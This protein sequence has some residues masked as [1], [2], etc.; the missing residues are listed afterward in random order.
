MTVMLNN[1]KAN[2][3]RGDSSITTSERA[4]RIYIQ[5]GAFLCVAPPLVLYM[6]TQKY[7]TESIERT[8]LVG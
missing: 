3:A 5:A 2:L 7:F 4:L 6:F 8:G 1:L